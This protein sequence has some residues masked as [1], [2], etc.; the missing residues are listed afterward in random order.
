MVS[1]RI[2][3]LVLAGFTAEIPAAHAADLRLK[4]RLSHDQTTDHRRQ[5]DN[6]STAEKILYQQFLEWL[7][8]QP[9]LAP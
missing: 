2:A 4:M 8:K 7:K 3:V 5:R 1:I 6:N 9:R